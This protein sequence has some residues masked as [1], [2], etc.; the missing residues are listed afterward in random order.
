MASDIETEAPILLALALRLTDGA[1]VNAG[2]T[3][4]DTRRDEATRLQRLLERDPPGYDPSTAALA[5][6][7]AFRLAPEPFQCLTHLAETLLQIEG[8]WPGALPG[9]QWNL[10][11]RVVDS[12]ALVA[13]RLAQAGSGL[14]ERREWDRILCWPPSLRGLRTPFDPLLTRPVPERH[15]HLG[16]ALPPS[17]YWAL[18]LHLPALIGN[19]VASVS[20]KQVAPQLWADALTDARKKFR[21]LTFE[22]LDPWEAPPSPDRRPG[23]PVTSEA[24]AALPLLVDIWT[25]PPED[26]ADG[27]PFC[28]FRRYQD[29]RSPRRE[30]EPTW[31]P[32]VELAGAEEQ[33][34]WPLAGT[35]A[36]STMLAALVA[37]RRFQWQALGRLRA[38]RL[39]DEQRRRYF[40]YLAVK[41][42]FHYWLVHD[43]GTRGLDR[44]ERT[45]ARRA[46]QGPVSARRRPRRA[47]LTERWEQRRVAHVIE[48]VL[49]DAA[50]S[51]P[52]RD[53]SHLPPV[54]LEIRVRMDPG[55]AF[56]HTMRARC[57]G[58]VD[59]LRAWRHAP[60]RVGFLIQFLR[61]PSDAPDANAHAW[62]SDGLLS[63]LADEPSLRPLI[64]GID[65]AGDEL[66]EPPRSFAGLYGSVRQF[67]AQQAPGEGR[68]RIRLGF[69]HHVG[70]DFRDLLTGIRHVDEAAHLLSMQPGDR[71]GHGLAV[72]WLPSEFY[73]RRRAV[74]ALT[75]EH[76]L[77]LLWCYAVLDRPHGGG[78]A[79][80]AHAARERLLRLLVDLKV[81]QPDERIAAALRALRPDGPHGPGGPGASGGSGPA[82][83]S[84]AAIAT[85]LGTPPEKQAEPLGLPIDEPGWVALVDAAQKAA[86]ARLLRRNLVLEVNPSSNL[87]IGGWR[88]YKELPYLRLNQ[89]G[90]RAPGTG[91][92][93]LP[94]CINSD[95]PGLFQTTLRN[96]YQQVGEA[97]LRQDYPLRAVTAWLDEARRV[98][99]DASFIPPWAPVGE[100]LREHIENWLGLED[101]DFDGCAEKGCPC[102]VRP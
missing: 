18:A 81:S 72:G 31:R 20:E 94:I 48:C 8:G 101:N 71:L 80:A 29:A 45:M 86:R 73:R 10:V 70:E 5:V 30:T 3:S 79:G 82:V 51:P 99:L 42:A 50:G 25:R 100:A 57:R 36:R 39:S 35:F 1:L 27:F 46:F 16:G 17:L 98:G 85:E 92:P 63:A 14:P 88:S 75:G 96:E 24:D 40:E 28:P 78:D 95:D 89:Y 84:E 23:N 61:V 60:L 97:L 65:V 58:I 37:E 64:V 34:Y 41:N 68:H 7:H 90:L 102:R 2:W 26:G 43:R 22:L 69:T 55:A 62:L 47:R 6:R 44:F 83:G 9:A 67:L 54:D 11:S 77:D 76:L 56:W 19:A 74:M 21:D 32:A 93:D 15:L 13:C 38:G 91:E 4:N 33:P 52:G 59:A 87:A 53:V 49:M 12:D 66:A